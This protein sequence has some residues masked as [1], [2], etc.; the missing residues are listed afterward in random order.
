VR[1]RIREIIEENLKDKDYNEDMVPQWINDITET[2]VEELFSSR[3]PFKYV[4]TCAIMQ[5]TGSAVHSATACYWDTVSDGMSPAPHFILC[6]SAAL[7]TRSCPHTLH[8]RPF[9]MF[10][11]TIF[12]CWPKRTSRDPSNRSMIC[13][14]NV[15]AVS[16]VHGM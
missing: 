7:A 3:K 8:Q 16:F 12:V 13:I 11:D 6:R 14:V 10:V 15:F 2:C 4:V 9:L 1:K 5:R